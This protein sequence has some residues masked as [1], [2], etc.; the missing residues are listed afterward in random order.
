MDRVYVVLVENGISGLITAEGVFHGDYAATKA[1]DYARSLAY[2][3]AERNNSL[4]V[5]DGY[6]YR[7]DVEGW[8]PYYFWA[9][10]SRFM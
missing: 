8:N 5:R 4:V 1:V 6:A 2:D 3:I 9:V 10:E 7:V